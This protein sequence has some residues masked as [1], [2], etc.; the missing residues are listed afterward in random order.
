[1]QGIA[2]RSGLMLR[3]GLL[4]AASFPTA[5]A[6]SL[7]THP[8][9]GPESA[10]EV[11]RHR[12][13]EVETLACDCVI[14]LG[15]SDGDTIVLDGVLYSSAPDHLRM[16]GWKFSERVF[17]LLVSG[18]RSWIHL[19]SRVEAH[20]GSS[21]GL[22][23]IDADEFASMWR[24]ATGNIDMDRILSIEDGGGAE[25]EV[26]V[27]GEAEGVSLVY[28]IARATLTVREITIEQQGMASYRLLLGGYEVI[29]DIVW[30]TSLSGSGDHGSFKLR[31]SDVELN[32]ALPTSAFKPSAKMRMQTE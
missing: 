28:R 17:D 9:S 12:S 27:S 8:W 31:M 15:H 19:S 13:A 25:F 4:L 18:G 29:S 11:L 26:I 16:A 7:P 20:A 22:D 21:S 5:C 10:L 23:A 1:M 14:Q 6:T 24:Y 32:S 3:L 2:D 30:P